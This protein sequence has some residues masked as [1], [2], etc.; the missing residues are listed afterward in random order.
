MINDIIPFQLKD[1]RAGELGIVEEIDECCGEFCQL[2]ALGLC[3]GALVRMMSPGKTC[4]V[5]VGES[6]LMLRGDQISAIRVTPL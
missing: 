1:L 6:R 2:A 4:A 3:R 5:Q